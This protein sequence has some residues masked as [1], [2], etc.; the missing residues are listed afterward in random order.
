VAT[1]FAAQPYAGLDYDPVTQ[2]VAVD[3]TDT[4]AGSGGGF[5]L[6]KD[7]VPGNFPPGVGDHSKLADLPHNAA[8][9]NEGGREEE[10]EGKKG[11]GSGGKEAQEGKDK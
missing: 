7:A 2:T 6:G 3:V 4:V 1:A 11:G 8:P 5:G 10:E 9:L